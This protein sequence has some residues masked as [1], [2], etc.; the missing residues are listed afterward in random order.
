MTSTAAQPT[1]EEQVLALKETAARLAAE[2]DAAM[3]MASQ[4]TKDLMS[5]RTDYEAR[6]KVHD[7]LVESL[8][9]GRETDASD[10]RRLN[11]RVLE[12]AVTVEDLQQQLDAARQQSVGPAPRKRRRILP[13]RSR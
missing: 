1:L 10:K 13:R 8:R 5:T 3:Q 12:L 4:A 2:R 6:L 11:A 7:A 9:I